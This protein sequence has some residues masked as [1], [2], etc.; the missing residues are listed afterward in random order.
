MKGKASSHEEENS[1]IFVAGATGPIL[2]REEDEE[3][4][5]VRQ[6]Q[7]NLTLLK[8][9]REILF[10]LYFSFPHTKEHYDLLRR[11][12]G[13]VFLANLRRGARQEH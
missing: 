12:H 6:G 8:E 4:E 9:G 5:G 13:S 2:G 1:S 3:E 7:E 10:F 11:F